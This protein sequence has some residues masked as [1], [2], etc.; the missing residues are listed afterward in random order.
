MLDLIFAL[1]PHDIGAAGLFM[2]YLFAFQSL[3]AFVAAGLWVRVWSLP[4][5]RRIGIAALASAIVL[6]LSGA[7]LASA[8]ILRSGV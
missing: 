4:D 7:R 5:C 2:A 8:V 3:S 1:F 6:I